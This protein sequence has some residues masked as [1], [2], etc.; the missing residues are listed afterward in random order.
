VID[1]GEGYIM[2]VVSYWSKK[3]NL[4][5]VNVHINKIKGDDWFEIDSLED[6]RVLEEFLGKE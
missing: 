3:D 6:L 2:S 1:S 4:K 5:N